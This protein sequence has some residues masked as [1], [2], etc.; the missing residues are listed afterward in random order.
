MPCPQ[1]EISTNGGKSWKEAKLQTP[2]LRMAHTRFTYDWSWDGE[3]TVIR[4][5]C[6][7]DQGA[8]QL[9]LAELNKNWGIT[10]SFADQQPR[11]SFQCPFSLGEG[12]VMGVCTMP[13]S[14]SRSLNSLV[15]LLAL[16][17]LAALGQSRNYNVGAPLSQEE[18]RSFDLMGG[19]EGEELPPGR[20]TA[21]EGADVY[22]KRARHATA[23]MGKEGQS[24]VWCWAVL[25]TPVAAL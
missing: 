25:A 3:E 12:P 22:A 18:I 24:S 4:S 6:T 9:S 10:G 15:S 16:V 5:R 11:H 13:C 1:V 23:G 8:T 21:K 19:P 20:G 14:L 17:L 7:D 2:V